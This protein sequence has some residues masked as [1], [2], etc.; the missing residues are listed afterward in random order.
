M[1]LQKP[2]LDSLGKKAANTHKRAQQH[3]PAVKSKR[4]G[5]AGLA[6]CQRTHWCCKLWVLGGNGLVGWARNELSWARS[7]LH[8]HASL[9]KWAWALQG[10]LAQL[11]WVPTGA[12]LSLHLAHG[13]TKALRHWVPLLEPSAKALLAW[14]HSCALH[15]PL[16]RHRSQVL[17][18]RRDGLE[19]PFRRSGRERP[20]EGRRP[21]GR[22]CRCPRQGRAE[23]PW[24]VVAASSHAAPNLALARVWCHRACRARGAVQTG[25]RPRK[26]TLTGKAL[27]QRGCSGA[28]NSVCVCACESVRARLRVCVHRARSESCRRIAPL[29]WGVATLATEPGCGGSLEK[30]ESVVGK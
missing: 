16:S 27:V 10:R 25:I 24:S 21:Q 23:A 30:T 19:Q 13:S 18:T 17:D 5:R 29:G 4:E 14:Q 3:T 2:K 20:G 28:S 15:S 22:P 11:A 1:S 7:S 9:A 8:T 26:A 12:L 6:Q